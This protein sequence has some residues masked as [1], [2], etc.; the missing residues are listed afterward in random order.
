MRVGGVVAAGGADVVGVETVEALGFLTVMSV[1]DPYRL[2]DRCY[3]SCI[4]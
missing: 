4:Q 2:M 3:S 1:V